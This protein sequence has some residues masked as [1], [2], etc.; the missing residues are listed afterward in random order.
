MADT[1]WTKGVPTRYG[2]YFTRIEGKEFI[3]D[4]IVVWVEHGGVRHE[5]R[6]FPADHKWLKCREYL[7]PISPSDFE[8]LMQLRKAAG[9]AD[10][11][12]HLIQGFDFQLDGSAHGQEIRRR[13]IEAINA[14]REALAQR[15]TGE[16]L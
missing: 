13:A 11:A 5:G 12:L 1:A 9:D 7:G 6:F 2:W 10:E 16:K 4:E 14:L 3:S 15:P 8:Q